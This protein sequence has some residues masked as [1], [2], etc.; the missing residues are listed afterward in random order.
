MYKKLNITELQLR[1]VSL[2]TDYSREYH[3]REIARILRLS[4]R[5]AQLALKNLEGKAAVESRMRGRTKVY[6]IKQTESAVDYLSMAEQYKAIAFKES[7]ALIAE[8]IA[9][10]KPHI[11]GIGA[12]FGSYAKGIEKKDSDLDIF[13]AG[14]CDAGAVKKAGYAYGIDINVKRYP[15]SIFEDSLSSDILLKEVLKSHVIFLNS[16]QFV[17]AVFKKWL[18]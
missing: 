9:K 7:H 10:I 13:V 4:P 1:I 8:V 18:K 2:F 12:I 3:I 11:K 14:E 15:F 17:T 5:A 16:E 6:S